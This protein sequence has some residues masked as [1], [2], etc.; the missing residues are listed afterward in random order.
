MTPGTDTALPYGEDASSNLTTLPTR[1][2]CH[3]RRRLGAHLL[4]PFGHDDG[5]HLR[6]LGQPD[7]GNCGATPTV[8]AS[9]NGAA[10]LTGYDDAAANMTAATYD[11]D[12][13]RTAA[14]KYTN[15]GQFCDPGLRLGHHPL[16]P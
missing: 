9:Y 11:G 7:R 3:L 5:L 16:G 1:G 10:Q 15:G 6:R 14:T 12:G 2:E 8:S 13:L 4:G